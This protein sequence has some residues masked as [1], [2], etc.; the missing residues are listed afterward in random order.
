M[1]DSGLEREVGELY[2][3]PLDQFTPRRDALAKRLRSEGGR[4][5]A[6]R[7]RKLK[8]PSRSAWAVNRGVHA[9]PSAAKRLVEAGKRLEAAQTAALGGK[10]TAQLKQAMAAQQE[11]IE[12]MLEAIRDAAGSELS[13]AVVDRARETLRALAGDGGL[14]AEF[15]AGRLTKD[16]EAVGFG[17]LAPAVVVAP[18]K[19]ESPPEPGAAARRE[20]EAKL[21]R[22]TRTLE[23]ATKRVA[24][25]RKGV[26]RAQRTLDE[27]QERLDEAESERAEREAERESFASELS[28]LT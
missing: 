15:S 1:A 27:A 8:K 11:A 4:E 14:Q 5:D 17:G 10:G 16:R 24:Q 25:M 9:D 23:A 22:S 3:L 26:E 12:E 13:A 18:K 20:V 19:K 6:N 21:K 2:A 28:K 7:V